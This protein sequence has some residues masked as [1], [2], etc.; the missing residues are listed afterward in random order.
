MCRFII[1]VLI[2]DDT[3]VLFA[4]FT[5]RRASDVGEHQGLGLYL[6]RLVAEYYG[7]SAYIGNRSDS[8]GVEA[9]I[10]LPL[11]SVGQGHSGGKV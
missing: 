1:E 9:T 4:P 11:I 6:V 5:S 10:K 2:E 8:S 7:G 3:E